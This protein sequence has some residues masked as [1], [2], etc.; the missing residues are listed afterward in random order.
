M[1]IRISI[2]ACVLKWLLSCCCSKW[3]VDFDVMMVLPII[4]AQFAILCTSIGHAVTNTQLKY[5]LRYRYIITVVTYKYTIQNTSVQKCSNVFS[6]KCI[7]VL[8]VEITDIPMV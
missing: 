1:C 7:K 5:R 2:L 6:I 4:Q 3:N 8:V